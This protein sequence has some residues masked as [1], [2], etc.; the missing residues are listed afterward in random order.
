M[1]FTEFSRTS[2]EMPRTVIN[3]S[4]FRPS[5]GLH[6][7]RGHECRR[8]LSSTVVINQRQDDVGP[9]EHGGQTAQHDNILCHVRDSRELVNELRQFPQPPPPAWSSNP[10]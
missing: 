1:H 6:P 10:I 9:A 4:G 3:T 2:I 7:P 8:C 5:G